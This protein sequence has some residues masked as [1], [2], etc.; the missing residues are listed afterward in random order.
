[1]MADS[2]RP[3]PDPLMGRRPQNLKPLEYGLDVVS[4]FEA[5]SR[6]IT[7]SCGTPQCLGLPCAQSTVKPKRRSPLSDG[8]REERSSKAAE[9][10]GQ[11]CFHSTQL[12]QGKSTVL[13]T[14]FS[15]PR[16]SSSMTL[17]AH[18]CLKKWGFYRGNGLKEAALRK[19]VTSTPRSA[20]AIDGCV[21]WRPTAE[22][23]FCR[24]LS[25]R[26]R[27]PSDSGATLA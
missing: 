15:R 10:F 3:D 23:A 12:H 7:V 22:R 17:T 14:V 4:K 16:I 27:Y 24:T 21:G 5:H 13:A 11:Q 6:C 2:L 19:L 18:F 20:H 25:M 1:M 26:F 9:S 8:S